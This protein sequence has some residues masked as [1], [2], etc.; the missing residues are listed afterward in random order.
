M[1]IEYSAFTLGASL[2]PS[3]KLTW[4][5]FSDVH[6]SEKREYETHVILDRLCSDI[7]E[8]YEKQGIPFPDLV[9]FTGDAANGLTSGGK[10]DSLSRQYHSFFSH[11]KKV[12][13][14]IS[15]RNSRFGKECTFIIPGNHDINRRNLAKYVRVPLEPEA[16]PQFLADTHA[17]ATASAL[18]P[19][20]LL[21]MRPLNEYI[22]ALRD[23]EYDYLIPD[24]YA[25]AT[26]NYSVD[27]AVDAIPVSVTG[28][29]SAW[30]CYGV[31]D[32]GH[33][34]VN[35]KRAVN[36]LKAMPNEHAVRFL[37]VH[38]PPNWLVGQDQ[39]DFRK[40][41]P[42]RFDLYL[43]GHEHHNYLDVNDQA[44][45]TMGAGAT[46][47]GDDLTYSISQ[48]DLG[49][50][51]LTSWERIYKSRGGGRGRR[52]R[53]QAMMELGRKP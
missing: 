36:Q 1:L 32:Y 21:A 48:L 17:F 11:L 34:A 8:K 28:I 40:C 2:V 42:G 24:T 33:V 5:H 29:N 18:S 46:D 45:V 3:K 16:V 53:R 52:T 12:E 7:T 10:A 22:Q 43:H 14:E 38:H 20:W 4:L 13:E 27:L 47:G 15:L 19:E 30:S 41:V 23:Y 51:T 39:Q 44:Y 35:F 50:K 31:N 26:L 6:F 49:S 37:L 25:E 9:F